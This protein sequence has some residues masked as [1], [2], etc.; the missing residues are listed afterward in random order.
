MSPRSCPGPG[1]W[2]LPVVHF[3]LMHRLLSKHCNPAVSFNM[4]KSERTHCAVKHS[5]GVLSLL[6][7]SVL[8]PPHHRGLGRGREPATDLDVWFQDPAGNCWWGWCWTSSPLT[9]MFLS[10]LKKKR[11][12]LRI[13]SC[14][15]IFHHCFWHWGNKVIECV[16]LCLFVM[17]SYLLHRFSWIS[18]KVISGFNY[19]N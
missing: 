1:G 8:L 15:L 2:W 19:F 10:Q 18:Q 3:S 4:A 7:H 9:E 14:L 16:C 11:S 5:Y 13:L 6:A 12:N 17:F